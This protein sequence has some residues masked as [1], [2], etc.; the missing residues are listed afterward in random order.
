MRAR[1]FLL[2]GIVL[3]LYPHTALASRPSNDPEAFRRFNLYSDRVRAVG[4]TDH[5]NPGGYPPFLDSEQLLVVRSLGDTVGYFWSKASDAI[6]LQ[7]HSTRPTSL[8]EYALNP[9]R[10]ATSIG[11]LSMAFNVFDGTGE[12]ADFGKRVLTVFGV[13]SDGDTIQW[14][15]DVG[16]QARDWLGGFVY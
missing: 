16:V 10:H 12:F 2:I 1:P 3:S 6:N 9:P 14:A 5:V 13:L 15:V 8:V 4:T 11:L 7:V